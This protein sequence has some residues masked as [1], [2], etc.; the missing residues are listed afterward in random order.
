M[1]KHIFK[2]E[3]PKIDILPNLGDSLN[4][5]AVVVVDVVDAVAVVVVVV[6]ALMK[7][8]WPIEYRRQE[9]CC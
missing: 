3:E 7:R 8:Q 2:E 6:A 4:G 9:I 5:V 1:P